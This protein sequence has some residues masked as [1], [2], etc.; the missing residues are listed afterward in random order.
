M[1]VAGSSFTISGADLYRVKTQITSTT[2]ATDS[3]KR[4]VRLVCFDFDQ[5]LASIHLFKTLA[6]DG[7]VTDAE[8]LTAFNTH[9]GTNGEVAAAV[10][11][12]SKRVKML[13]AG[14][15]ALKD[16]GA[17]LFVITQ[18]NMVIVENALKSCDLKQYFEGVTDDNP[19]QTT[20]QVLMNTRFG[21]RLE[22]HQALLVDD[23]ESNFRDASTPQ[24]LQ[25]L[26]SAEEFALF[27]QPKKLAPK[28]MCKYFFKDGQV[29][30]GLQGYCLCMGVKSGGGIT[31][32]H[33][34][35][36]LQYVK[37][38][39]TISVVTTVKQSS[40][41]PAVQLARQ[42][43][44]MRQRLEQGGA[45][46]QVAIAATVTVAAAP[47]P[48]L[49]PTPIPEARA[50]YEPLLSILF[51]K[52]AIKR[53]KQIQVLALKPPFGLM[54]KDASPELETAARSFVRTYIPAV[55]AALT[56]DGHNG[57]SLKAIR[58]RIKEGTTGTTAPVS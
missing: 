54:P 35:S 30:A 3:S 34:D 31:A 53:A 21:K 46:N 27:Y 23:K 43:S 4:G 51:D 36:V 8:F 24:E 41:S 20:V 10:F 50:E 25:Q 16:A 28:A 40:L 5:T 38:I 2:E 44:A 39:K 9:Y 18:G 33:M 7:C 37:G 48:R 14:L 11:G 58:K 6:R 1:A 42:N 19:K 22:F 32:A 29:S 52:T 45:Q 26:V 49:T 57:N 12:G 55:Q 15:Q 56:K 47:K 13:Q 17:K